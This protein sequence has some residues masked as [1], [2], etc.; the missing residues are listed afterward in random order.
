MRDPTLDG[1]SHVMID[2]VH[3]R[4]INT[5]F[6]LVLLRA[7]LRKRPELRVVLMSATLDAESFSK[8]FAKVSTLKGVK[9]FETEGLTDGTEGETEASLSTPPPA[10]LL[11]VPT[12]PRHPVEMF[13]L[14]DLA[15]EDADSDSD[16][17]FDDEEISEKTSPAMDGIGAKL[18][19]ALLEA[20][21]E[22]LERE[23]EEAV[24]EER[25]A[26]AFESEEC[27]DDDEECDLSG[28]GGETH[29][30]DSDSGSELEQLE[31]EIEGGGPPTKGRVARGRTGRLSTR[32]RTLRRA[33]EMRRDDD[34][35]VAP[36]G[37]AVV[38]RAARSAVRK[39]RK[40]GGNDKRER[41]E[42][43]VALA[44]EVAR[45]VALK[46]TNAGRSGSVLVFL[47]GWDE[48]KEIMKTLEGLPVDEREVM[49]IIPLHSQVP[50]EEQQT[51]FDACPDGM[52][53]IILAT[54]I[55]ESSVTIDDVLAVVD[56]GLVREMS[57][58]PES[59]MSMM[60]TEATS[61]A[62]ATQRAGRA[63]RVAPGVCYRLYS[64]AMFEAM[65]ERP[66]PEIQRTALEATCLQTC[67][68]TN[69]GVQKFLG[70]AMDPPAEE[71]VRLA[72]ERLISLGA[73]SEVKSNDDEGMTYEGT[74]YS[75]SS[76]VEVLTPLGS[77]PSQLPLD[78]ATGRMLITG[79]VTQCLD[80]V[81]TAAACM[82]SR[83]PFI[84]P[85]GMRDEAQ[86]A[87]RSFCDTSDHL[88]VLRAY[89]EWRNVL[90]EDGMDSACRWARNNFL[91]IQGLQTLTSLR[92]QLLNE[93]VRTGLVHSGDLGYGG[94]RNRELAHDAQVN[95]HAGNEA[96]TVSVLLTGLPGN[97]ASRRQQAHF[98]VMRTSREDSAGLH[99]GCVAFQRTPP[100]RKSDWLA[101][102]NWFLYKEMVLSSQVFLRDC[103]SVSAE[104]I[105]LF[106]GSKIVPFT[107]VSPG[108]D[109][110]DEAISQEDVSDA[111]QEKASLEPP[112][113]GMDGLPVS[114]TP[115]PTAS[116]GNTKENAPAAL[117]DDWI[118][119]GSSCADTSELLLDVR[120]ELDAALAFKVMHPKRPIHK[121]SAEI[122][123][124]V[125]A[126][127]HIVESRN[128]AGVERVRRG[129][130]SSG[131]YERFGNRDGFGRQPERG[132]GG[133]NNLRDRPGFGRPDRP[134][135]GGKSAGRS[136][137]RL[138]RDANGNFVRTRE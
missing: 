96:L 66:T 102:P 116:Q 31:V 100:K 34:V 89:A 136:N 38:S 68:M 24:A 114:S 60:G 88:A 93:L 121:A 61:R 23:L 41:E 126:T 33:V 111:S 36:G 42:L 26:D 50:Q 74:S 57:Y 37:R 107:P 3:E 87:R 5:D 129:E 95:R 99:P 118:V 49:K 39:G 122:I 45:S 82:S 125:A 112:L 137:G 128:R 134:G 119:V 78:P 123:D 14:E 16:D 35:V 4:D 132:G 64:K 83:D 27:A 70:E 75:T 120:R 113:L 71:T 29:D 105:M 53:K 86:R 20:Q 1:I 117:L 19:L 8:Y 81:L 13:Y 2:E 44:A 18:S 138:R 28:D 110:A 43:V 101:L 124:A 108:V 10:P 56:S 22:L 62:S 63:G 127:M 47:P 58:N 109:G 90:A 55:A 40:G 65:P 11:S 92:S 76:A 9:G 77:L 21:D 15:G 52:V 72:M 106:G 133:S 30:Y 91:S 97:L 6:L 98:G 69:S 54:N 115:I 25:A 12:K 67:S 85:T 130:S 59:A 48:I 135:F 104:Q 103:S 32:I 17:L 94:G 46:E 7:L 73:I 79:V 131:G 84:V 80:P 51:V